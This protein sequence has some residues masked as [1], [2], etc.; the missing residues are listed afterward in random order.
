MPG[1]ANNF[2]TL[3]ET[4]PRAEEDDSGGGVPKRSVKSYESFHAAAEANDLNAVREYVKMHAN[5]NTLDGSGRTPLQVVCGSNSE[6]LEAICQLLLSE[7][8][9]PN[10]T[11]GYKQMTPLHF[12]CSFS[13]KQHKG[14][15]DQRK[16][17]RRRLVLSRVRIIELLLSKGADRWARNDQNEL[18]LHFAASSGSPTMVHALLSGQTGD[19]LDDVRDLV[20]A[21]NQFE[22]DGE[23]MNGNGDTPLGI[24]TRHNY[25]EIVTLL[26]ERGASVNHMNGETGDTASHRAVYKS[27]LAMLGL[28]LDHGGNID[29]KN[30]RGY[31]L[32]HVTAR[33]DFDSIAQY[34]LARGASVNAQDKFFSTPLMCAAY[35][36]NWKTLKVLLQFEADCGM[37]KDGAKHSTALE[38][39]TAESK[40]ECARLIRLYH[41]EWYVLRRVHLVLLRVGTRLN[42]DLLYLRR[43]VLDFLAE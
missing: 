29:A 12:A 15:S 43:T 16:D 21:T 11:T 17:A 37:T 18:S 4:A 40:P 19:L 3:H 42:V 26:L 41:R 31:S 1:L 23:A 27:N 35:W 13:Q 36:G 38:I 7:G 2:L 10:A 5:V 33:N 22:R 25:M 6:G 9:D 32:L 14:W 34:L 8:A 24:A 20:N 28:L 39:A 30:G